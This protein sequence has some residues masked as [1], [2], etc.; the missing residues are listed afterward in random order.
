MKFLKKFPKIYK[1]LFQNLGAIK[2]TRKEKI[3]DTL[4]GSSDFHTD[5]FTSLAQLSEKDY[6]EETRH[7][8]EFLSRAK[9]KKTYVLPT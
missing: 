1:S 5:A 4:S 7:E 3:L 2:H 9:S 8:K 6:L